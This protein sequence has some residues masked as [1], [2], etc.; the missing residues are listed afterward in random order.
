[1]FDVFPKVEKVTSARP[2]RQAVAD[3]LEQL[4][5]RKAALSLELMS[6]EDA[7]RNK[8]QGVRGTRAIPSDTE[9]RRG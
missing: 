6:L 3:E 8:K 5:R 9:V 1:M 4:Q 7:S 2:Q